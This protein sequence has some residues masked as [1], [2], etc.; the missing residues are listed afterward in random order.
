MT[1]HELRQFFMTLV[2]RPRTRRKLVVTLLSFGYKHGLP[3]RRR[4]GVRRPVPAEPA[5][6]AGAAA[7]D[8]TRSRPSWRSWSAT[9]RPREFIER[10]EDYVRYRRAALHARREGYLTVAIGCTGGRHRSVMIA[11]RLRKALAEPPGRRRCASAIATS[12]TARDL[13]RIRRVI[14]VVVV[15]H[16]QLATE[17]LNA[18][19]MIVGDLPRF[20]A[21]SIGW[22]DDVRT[23]GKTSRRPS[24]ACDGDGTAACCFSPTCSAER[25]RT[26][27][28]TFIEAG[29]GRGHHRREPA[30]AHQAGGPGEVERSAGRRARH[31]RARAERHLGRVGFPARPRSRAHDVAAASPSSNSS[32]CTR[33]RPRSSCIWRRKFQSHIRVARGHARDGRQEHH[34]PAA[35]GGGPRNAPFASAPKGDD[36]VERRGG[37]GGTRRDR[38]RRGRMQRLTGIGA[39]PGVVAGRAVVLICASRCC[40]TACRPRTWTRARSV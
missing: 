1:V 38:I 30:D 19:E 35:A 18:A 24:S 29:P 34:G 9:R 8:G 28:M 40:A 5:L 7:A 25:R 21:V 36:E 13:S 11:E 2:A 33:A 32:A 10:L 31:A 14:G 4:P 22:H 3:R 26:S 6:R 27:A 23:R 12:A 15:T 16:G 37:A 39:S 17:L 20:A